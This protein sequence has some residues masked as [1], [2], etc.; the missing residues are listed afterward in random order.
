MSAHGAEGVPVTP[1][2]RLRRALPWLLLAAALAFPWI[3]G[4]LDQS[5]YIG[6]IRRILIFAIA[7]ASLNFILGYGGMVSLGHAAFFGIGAYTVGA[8]VMEGVGS[9]WIAWPLAAAV[10]ASLAG[11]RTWAAAAPIAASPSAGSARAQRLRG[12]SQSAR[13]ASSAARAAFSGDAC[14]SRAARSTRA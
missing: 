1:R 7:A 14:A 9:A 8:L 10:A 3:A 5:F 11:G 6:V 2:Q 13:A 12:T 4:A